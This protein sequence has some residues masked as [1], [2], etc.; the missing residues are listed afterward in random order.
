MKRRSR[1][2]STFA[3]IALTLLASACGGSSKLDDLKAQMVDVFTTQRGVEL[4]DIECE[5]GAAVEPNASFLCTSSVTDGE[6]RLRV[7]V[8]IDADG[9][10]RFEQMDAIVIL[11]QIEAD[12]AADLTF[13][14]GT[15]IAVSCR[16]ELV[17]V[18]DGRPS[19]SIRS[20]V[21]LRQISPRPWV[22]M[23]LI[24]SGV[25]ICAGITRSPSFSRSS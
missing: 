6:G 18:I 12:V 9:A 20:P 14:L 15:D 5:D 21:R 13:G 11:G 8:S 22:A 7:Q 23:K 16:D 19:W 24:A 10:A 3:L 17:G 1:V 4:V 2:E 25:A